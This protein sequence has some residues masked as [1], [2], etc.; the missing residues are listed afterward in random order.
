VSKPPFGHPHFLAKWPL[1]QS[2][3]TEFQFA[4]QIV[5]PFGKRPK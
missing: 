3:V 1:D 2:G 4:S 5:H